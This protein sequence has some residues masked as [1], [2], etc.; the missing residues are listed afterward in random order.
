[1]MGDVIDDYYDPSEEDVEETVQ[2]E[3]I[4]IESPPPIIK[5]KKN[6]PNSFLII[7]FI[8]CTMY[9]ITVGCGL[10][11]A[12]L[13]VNFAMLSCFDEDCVVLVD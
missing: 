8:F 7:L 11:I 3:E 2:V 10:F 5:K 4:E 13:G 6:V 9:I 12:A 1:M